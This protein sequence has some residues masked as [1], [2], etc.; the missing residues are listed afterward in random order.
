MKI[1][2]VPSNGLTETGKVD[3]AKLEQTIFTALTSNSQFNGLPLFCAVLSIQ[4]NIVELGVSN[5][6]HDA[7][8]GNY[9]NF[10]VQ[11]RFDELMPALLGQDMRYRIITN[12]KDK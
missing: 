2:Q 5:K 6:L 4:D 1:T 7:I 11:H 3:P 8:V 9:C 12:P 10:L